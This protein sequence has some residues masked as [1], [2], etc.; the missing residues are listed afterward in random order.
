MDTRQ[1]KS[2]TAIARTGSFARAAELVNLTP[3]AVSQQIQALETE[4]GASLFDRSSR[5]PSRSSRAS[6]AGWPKVSL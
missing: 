3:T 6:P 5:P 2:L 4:V 1:L